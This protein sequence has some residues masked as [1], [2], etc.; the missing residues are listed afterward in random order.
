MTPRSNPA[1]ES[2][3]EN[4]Y[5]KEKIVKILFDNATEKFGNTVV[6][7]DKIPS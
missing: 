2:D 7:Y 6:L 5:P 3:C 1:G 4:C